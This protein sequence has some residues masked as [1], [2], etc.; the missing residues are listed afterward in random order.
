VATGNVNAEGKWYPTYS[1]TRTTTFTAVS[2]R[3]EHHAANWASR[4]LYA[5]ALVANRIA[6]YYKTNKSGSGIIYRVFHD[7]ATL[8]LY[9]KVTP[10][11]H[12][13][14]LEPET[15][16][17]DKGAGWHADTKYGCDSLDS[18]SHD[19]APF[20]L[21]QAS[22]ARFRIRGDYF[23]SSKDAANLDAQGPW[24]YFIVK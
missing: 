13:E 23:R 8:T 15:E 14:C 19:T 4:T 3:N 18:A 5:Y 2:A 22:D 20:S 10:N 7:S 16:Q 24:L 17:Y 9:S 1:I 11:K 6:G 12:G 21:S